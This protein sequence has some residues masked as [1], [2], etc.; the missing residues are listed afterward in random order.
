MTDNFLQET[1]D[2]ASKDTK[3][4]FSEVFK[5]ETTVMGLQIIAKIPVRIG[6]I[7]LDIGK[8]LIFGTVFINLKSILDLQD[9]CL[10][11][12]TNVDNN[13]FDITGYEEEPPK[14]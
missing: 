6:N 3:K 8:T 14:G 5:L 13:L 9:K 2:N 11:G 7:T 1:F 12:K 4:H 10:T